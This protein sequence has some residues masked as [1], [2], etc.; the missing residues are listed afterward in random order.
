VA[1]SSK[2]GG[3]FPIAQELVVN[4]DKIMGKE[5]I[6]ILEFNAKHAEFRG[7]VGIF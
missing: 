5:K 1:C 2:G 7:I 4:L 6:D 3:I